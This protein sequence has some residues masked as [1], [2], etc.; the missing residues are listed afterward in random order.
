MVAVGVNCTAPRF[1]PALLAAAAG[2]TDLPLVA[3]PNGGD[4]WDP[5]ARRWVSEG[6]VARTSQPPSPAGRIGARPGSAAAAGPDRA[7]IQALTDALAA[8]ILGPDSAV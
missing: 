5:A 7:D 8:Q 3:Y 6:R 1:V 2:A 4:R